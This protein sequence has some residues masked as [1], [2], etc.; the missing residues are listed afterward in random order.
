MPHHTQATVRTALSIARATPAQITLQERLSEVDIRLAERFAAQPRFHEFVRQAFDKH[1]P[2]LSPAPDLSLTFISHEDTRQIIEPSLMDAVVRRIVS[3]KASDL[4]ERKAMFLRATDTGAEPAPYTALTPEAFDAFLDKLAADLPAQYTQY[5]KRYWTTACSPTDVRT[6]KQWLVATRIDQLKAEVALLKSDGLFSATAATLFEKIL[7]YPDA[8][9][10]QALEDYRPCVYA[11][12]LQDAE[13][14]AMTLHGAFI[15]TSRDPQDGEVRWESEVTAPVVRPVEPSANVGTVVL[16]TP[17]NGLEEFESL[18]T[19]DRE[20]HRRL[21]HAMEFATLSELVT[22]TD[23]PRVLALQGKAPER[24]SL[25]YLEHLDSPFEYGIESQCQLI[26]KNLESTLA[27]YVKQ[28]VHADMANLP[29]AIDRLTDLRR[30]FATQPILQARLRKQ[31]KARLIAFL[32]GASRADQEAWAKAFTNYTEAL[33]SLSEYEGLPSLAQFSDRRQLLAYSNRQLRAALEAEHGLTVN[34]DDIVV[35]TKEPQLPSNS[36]P[37]G[38]PGTSIREPGDFK[39]KHRQRTLTELALDNLSGIDHN[40]TRYSRLSL[41]TTEASYDGLTLEQVKE[42][43]RSVNV[44]QSYQDF[45]K[46][47]LVSSPAALARKHSFASLFERQIRLDAIEARI[48]GDFLPDRLERGFNWVQAVLDAP[49]DSDQ[50]KIVEGHRIIVQSLQLRGQR[51]RGVLLF[52]TASAGT[53]SVVVYTPGAPEG[54]VFNE[55][56][57]ERLITDFVHNSSWR[58]YLVGRLDRAAQAQVLA[59]LKG[60]G[61]V[62]TVHMANIA[63]NIF[64]DAYEVEAN[65]AINDATAQVTTTRQTDVETGLFVATTVIDV[66][67]LVLPV[68]VTLPVGVARSL[69]SIFNAVE[70]AQIGDR[71][72]AAHHIVRALAEFTGVLIDSVMGAALLRGT[73]AVKVEAGSRALD[74]QTALRKKPDGLLELKGWEGKGIYYK[75]A[76]EFSA[77]QY[78]LH[79]RKHWY[80]LINEGFEQTWRIRDARKAYQIYYSPIRRSSR[81]QWEIGNAANAPRLLGGNSPQSALRDLYPFLDKRQV[82]RVFEAFAFPRGRE[83]EL[84][85]SFVQ[86]LRSGAALDAFGQYLLVSDQILRMRLLGHGVPAGFTGGGVV[87]EPSASGSGTSR[88]PAPLPPTRVRPAHERFMEWGQVIDAADVQLQNAELGLYRRTGGDPSLVGRDYIKIDDHYYP[89]LPAGSIA[90]PHLAFRFDDRI[91]VRHFAQFEHLIWADPYSQPRPVFFASEDK[92]WV[93]SASLPFEKT[94]SAYV[95]D[96][97]PTFSTSSQQQ[98]AQTL[99]GLTNPNGLT[100]SGL[101]R[102]HRTLKTWRNRSTPDAALGG[103]VGDPL[104]LLPATPKNS[105]GQWLLG[106]YSTL[107]NRVQLRTEGVDMLL[108]AVM[109]SGTEESIRVLMAERLVGSGYEMLSGYRLGSELLFRRP[110]RPQLFWLSLRR[111]RGHVVDGSAYV[112]PRVELMDTATQALVTRAQASN[113]LVALVGGVRLPS[114][115]AALEIFVFKA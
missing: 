18:A 111:V 47:S 21:S 16:F 64:E 55:Y 42:L 105:T 71:A 22:D 50:R 52:A 87:R 10:R 6:Y 14:N 72:G 31:C 20:L 40:F 41:K 67:T 27:R 98:A 34:P 68:H 63:K 100:A 106:E 104:S 86:H 15:L 38:A 75:P 82:E 13:A 9:S 91:D 76:N 66:L 51:V 103:I 32:Q 26:E 81:G 35:H 88:P 101:A 69:I 3:G 114:A 37:S 89:I 43:V 36:I 107:Y 85:L 48:N 29:G 53:S 23:Q 24:D 108:H 78:F 45:L 49:E 93:T 12:A 8:K 102:L 112:A 4:A 96:A 97:F 57:K 19:L 83:V 61:D 90:S 39:F 58:D 73:P 115:G 7:R 79:E 25:K 60:R 11:V 84:G 30:A 56:V 74:P 110:G 109:S 113:D 33:A 92:L 99:F 2:T 28:G 62:S 65:F 44:G 80:S 77:R 59:T 46:A 54:R 5:L 1:F 95:A 70:T 17:N 94:I